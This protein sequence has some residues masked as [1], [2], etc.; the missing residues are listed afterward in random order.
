MYFKRYLSGLLNQALRVMPVV[1]LTGPRQAGKSTL[2]KNDDVLKT[3]RYVTLDDVTVLA[4]LKR[5][6]MG[7]LGEGPVVVDEAQ[8][9]PELFAVIKRMV[10]LDRRPG[11]LF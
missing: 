11:R 4:A 9:A 1:V 10:D 2:L 3:W 7:V 6:P 5:D 8:R